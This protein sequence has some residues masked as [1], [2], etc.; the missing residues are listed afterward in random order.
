MNVE[1]IALNVPDPVAMADWYLDHLG[2]KLA[3]SGPPPANGI[4]PSV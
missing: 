1:H 3:R 2:M 4:P